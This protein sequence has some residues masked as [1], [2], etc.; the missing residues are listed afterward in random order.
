MSLKVDEERYMRNSFKMSA[1][2]QQCFRA[3]EGEIVQY[4]REKEE[5]QKK[6][7]TK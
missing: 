7:Q 4:T 3:K 1:F 6:L 5:A 2:N